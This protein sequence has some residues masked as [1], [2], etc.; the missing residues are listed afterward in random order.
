MAVIPRRLDTI[1]LDHAALAMERGFAGYVIPVRCTAEMLA[2]RI[3]VEQVDPAA[4]T[5]FDLEGE[6]AGILLVARRGRVSC[7]AGLGL[8]PPLRRRG[9]GREVMAGAIAEARARGDERLLLEV[10][11]G[12]G[13]AL[14]LYGGLGFARTRRLAS[15]RHGGDGAAAGGL[16][17]VAPA[18]AGQRVAGWSDEGLPWQLAPQTLG[19]AAIPLRGFTLG[20]R[21]AALVDDTGAEVRLAGIAVAPDARRQGIGG[22]LLRRLRG[23]FP[24]RAWTIPA[25]VP[26]D[27]A[28]GLLARDGWGPGPISQV[29]MAL[30]F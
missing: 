19:L 24:G 7:I 27:L 6:P 4:S 17:E 22:T 13:P 16:E 20:D 3:R 26:E 25:L 29:E 30:G 21:A 15:Y 5:V 11:L 14:A 8:A 28:A 2:R 18:V 1:P 23:R 9:L 12:N 10:I